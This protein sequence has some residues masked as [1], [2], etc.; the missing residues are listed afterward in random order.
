MEISWIGPWLVVLLTVSIVSIV[1]LTVWG[2][3]HPFLSIIVATFF[4]GLGGNLLG[5]LSGFDQPVIPDLIKTISGGFGGILSY[6]GLVIVFGTIIGK[7][8]EKTGAAVTVAEVVLKVVG[9]KRPALA[10]SLIG[11]VVSIP[12]FC[13][14][15]YVV[16]SSLKKSLAQA[17]ATPLPILSVALATGLYASHTFV[18]PTPGP[19]AAA[20]NLGLQADGLIW[21]ML[22]GGIVSLVAAGAGLLWAQYRVPVLLR[23]A[24]QEDLLVSNKQK[25]VFFSG[26]APS[27]VRALVPLLVPVL[28]MGL[29]SVANFPVSVSEAGEKVL[30]ASGVWLEG[31]TLLGHPTLALF[32]GVILALALLVP[33]GGEQA[34][35]VWVGEG[36][37]DAAMILLI[38]GAGG[39]LGAVIKASPLAEYLQS[40]FVGPSSATGGLGL[41]VLFLIAA[42]LKTAQGS[43][44]AALI[45][46][47]T[48]AA[49]LLPVFGLN[50]YWGPVPMGQVLAVLSIGAG[51]MVV[52]HVNDSY[53]WVVSQ[54]AS[55][56]LTTAYRAQTLATLIQGL[57]AFATVSLLA[58]FFL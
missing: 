48:M 24:E 44:T 20:G 27:A 12:V 56:K 10:M 50:G 43:S 38:T 54:F 57:A 22:F 37:K 55:M 33:R 14:S 16:L 8:L 2:R 32:V 3:L 53:F 49:P 36:L 9:R 18:P 13:D 46:T 29:G 6:I 45:I 30:L 4:Y 15:G 26:E 39:A 23:K 41:L 58:L 40:L 5:R 25:G 17:T 28:L 47:S 42:L 21:V 11:W 1:G 34:L 52:S 7:I 35:T 19:I 31:L 51:A